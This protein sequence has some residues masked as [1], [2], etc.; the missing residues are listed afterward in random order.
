MSRFV[1]WCWVAILCGCGAEVVLDDEPA[2][3]SGEGGFLGTGE[4]DVDAAVKEACDV[5]KEQHPECPQDTCTE[6]GYELF[7]IAE[8]TGC[9]AEAVDLMYCSVENANEVCLGHHACD[10]EWKVLD[11]CTRAYCETNL[12]DCTF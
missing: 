7:N 1:V 4:T 6:Q 3:Q 2:L 5:L 8:I 11:A 10:P 9:T 12:D